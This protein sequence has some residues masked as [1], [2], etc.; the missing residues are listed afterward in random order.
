MPLPVMISPHRKRVVAGTG[1]IPS[2]DWNQVDGI[3]SFREPCYALERCGRWQ[4][5]C[6]RHEYLETPHSNYQSTTACYEMA[7]QMLTSLMSRREQEV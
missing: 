6:P 5:I 4:K 1:L 7:Q 3:V 2:P